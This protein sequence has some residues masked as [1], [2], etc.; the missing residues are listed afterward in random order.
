MTLKGITK[1]S[2]GNGGG[3]GS[4]ANVAADPSCA[5]IQIEIR[6]LSPALGVEVHGVDIAQPLSPLLVDVIKRLW[7]D[8]LVLLFRDQ[9]IRPED[10]L[11]FTRHFGPLPATRSGT[12]LDGYPDVFRVTNK[13]VNGKKT[14]SHNTGQNWHADHSWSDTPA[15]GSILYCREIP[16]I[17]GDT[18]FANMVLAHERLSPHMQRF[19]GELEAVHDWGL[20]AG[21]DKRDPTH[22][23]TMR[24]R[25]PPVVHDA[26][27][28]HERTGQ[29]AL[30]LGDRVRH[31]VGMTPE[32][33]RPFLDFLVRHATQPLMTYRHRWRVGDLI[34]WDNRR[35]MHYAIPDY[36]GPRDML[37]TTIAGEKIGR[38]T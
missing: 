17:G 3:R 5:G 35:T 4:G 9:D 32:E 27:L 31:F 26:V 12:T 2:T 21:L 19:L 7:D 22:V 36:D 23:A 6:R 25:R 24:G 16:D 34:L 29:K 38:P 8:H 33:S 11:A 20:V 13:L 15:I 28:T 18:M 14:T 37:R 30:Y 1:T 10:Q